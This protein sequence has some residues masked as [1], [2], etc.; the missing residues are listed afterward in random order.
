MKKHHAPARRLLDRQDDYPRFASDLC[1]SFSN[2]EAERSIRMNKLQIKISG[3]MR[4]MAGAGEFCALRSY[5]GT[6]AATTSPRSK[7]SP[8]PSGETLGS[9]KP[10]RRH[11]YKTPTS[12][13]QNRGEPISYSKILGNFNLLPRFRR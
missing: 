2:N 11:R 12:P 8:A 9:P 5:L 10:D 1:V 4:S 13:S 3:C 6:A 7:R